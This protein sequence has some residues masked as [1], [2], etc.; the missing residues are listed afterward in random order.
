V[1]LNWTAGEGALVDGKP[2]P[3]QSATVLYLPAGSHTIEHAPSRNEISVTDLNAKLRSAAVESGK[4]I[5]F[6]Y[7][8]DSRAIVRFDRK[9]AR[10]EV[11]GEL[12]PAE[13][14]SP[15][16]AASSDCTVLLPRGTHR[17]TAN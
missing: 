7:S 13:L 4:R 11:D 17:V 15:T 5:T 1:E 14:L 9:P 6:E 8:S 2:W 16:C 3:M 10:M 12:F